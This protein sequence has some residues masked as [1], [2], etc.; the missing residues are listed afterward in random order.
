MVQVKL[1]RFSRSKEQV[2]ED[3]HSEPQPDSPSQLQTETQIKKSRERPK[4]NKVDIPQQ[5]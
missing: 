5:Q 1:K 3:I 4:I 2:P